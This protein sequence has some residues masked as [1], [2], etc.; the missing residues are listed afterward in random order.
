MHTKAAMLRAKPV[1][2]TGTSAGETIA[3]K[4]DSTEEGE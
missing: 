1:G 3:E 4:D 2:A